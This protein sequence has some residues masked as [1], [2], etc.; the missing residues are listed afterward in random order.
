MGWDFNCQRFECFIMKY[1]EECLKAVLLFVLSLLEWPDILNVCNFL[2]IFV[3]HIMKLRRNGVSLVDL[4]FFY[5]TYD[6]LDSF[7]FC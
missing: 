5:G 4:T 7:S 1:E 6:L 2:E 3:R